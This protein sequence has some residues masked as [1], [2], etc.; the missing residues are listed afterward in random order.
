M[1]EIKFNIISRLR[2]IEAEK[3]IRI[4]YACESGSWVWGFPSVNSDYD[5]RFVFVRYVKI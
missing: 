3:N 5:I 2:E 4:L 1:D